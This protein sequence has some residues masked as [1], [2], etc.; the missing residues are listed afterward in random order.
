MKYLF[1]FTCMLAWS[2][3]DAQHEHHHHG[4]DANHHMNQRPF[5][6]L[7][8][9]F[10]DPSRDEWQQ[11]D[12]VMARLGD[13]S[14]KTVMDI[15]SGTGY[16][17]FRMARAGA[18]VICAD[19]DQRF[20]DYIIQKRDSIGSWA[21]DRIS[22]R[23]VPFDSADLQPGE[24]DLVLI[25]DTYHHIEDRVAYFRAV[26]QGLKPDGK[27]VVIDFFKEE[28]PVGPPV[29]MKMAEETV[30]GE[31]HEAGFAHV[32]VDVETLPYQYIITVW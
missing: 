23:L 31:L 9:H 26:R 10:E 24:A 3:G 19:V 6:D 18:N 2:C 13:L 21:G 29:D 4:H 15:G 11:P 28:S 16:F 8:A 7:V 25:V 27:L 1:W 14:G 17:S 5:G 30:M 20:L 12:A 22:T 32:A